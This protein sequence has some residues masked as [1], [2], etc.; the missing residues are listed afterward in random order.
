MIAYDNAIQIELDIWH[1][2]NKTQRLWDSDPTLWTNTD[3]AKW[4]GWLNIATTELGTVPRIN[5]LANKIKS[6]GF[7]HVVVLGM[8]GSSLC[9]AMLADTFREITSYPRLHVLDSTDPMQIHNL[10]NNI[11]LTKTIFIVSSKSGS[12]LEPNIFKDYFYSRLQTVLNKTEVGDRFIAITDPGTQ[13]ANLASEENFQTVFDGTPSIGGRYSALSS[14]GMVPAG[15][16]GINVKEFLQHA[17]S[18]AQACSPNALPQDNPG[19]L[20]GIMLGVYANHG[21]NKVTLV[22]SPEIKS[23]GA[24]LE[25]LLAESTGKMGK[26]LIPVDQEPLGTPDVYG[27]DRV[28]IYIRLDNTVDTAQDSALA[29]IEESG[30]VVIRLTLAD[31]KYLGAE[32]FKWEMATAVAGSVMDLNP[33]DQPD[34]EASKVRALQLTHEYEKTGKIAEPM[35]I[36]SAHG[37]QLF[38][39]GSN[40]HE[41]M[42]HLNAPASMEEYLRAHFSR[43][44]SGDY[45]DLAAFIEISDDN[46]AILQKCRTAI[47]DT[48]KVATCLGFGPR[49]LHSTGQ[50]YKGGP[51]TGVFLQITAH[52]TADIQVPDHKYTFGLVLAAQAQADFE[53]LAQRSR[54][55]LRIHIGNDV[56]AGLQQLYKFIQ[57]AM[58]QA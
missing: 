46:T 29:M 53:V 26:G 58:G 2:E 36:F 24:W 55:V 57:H 20:L 21:K 40:A 9:P 8:G 14:F 39:D 19:V 27:N 25:Q 51:N 56:G 52:H 7:K 12:T 33:F 32:L 16:M 4:T 41:I 31:K 22:V 50:A 30:Q 6:A 1:A 44:K 45:V 48:K 23:L 15:L 42:Q 18:M 38:T 11:D 28:F 17:E 54:R 37:I 43:I 47:R 49:F 10:E 3:E 5:T 13:L 34:V 35:A